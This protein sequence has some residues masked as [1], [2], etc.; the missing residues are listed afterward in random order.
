MAAPLDD[1]ARTLAA[2][3]SLREIAAGLPPVD[4][5]A[6]TA[7]ARHELDARAASVVASSFGETGAARPP[8]PSREELPH[9]RSS[10]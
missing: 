6:I 4:A 1:R 3:A 8:L 10:D 5:V 2:L 7:E 9:R